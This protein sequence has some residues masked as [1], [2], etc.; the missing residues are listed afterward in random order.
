MS[1]NTGNK[2]QKHL[3]ISAE[4]NIYIYMYN[5]KGKESEDNTFSNNRLQ[6]QKRKG[7]RGKEPSLRQV[8]EAAAEP[9]LR[10]KGGV[11]MKACRT[12]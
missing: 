6:T 12:N 1:V 4:D 8:K 9:S 11:Q 2:E 3:K 5:L 10:G 7:R